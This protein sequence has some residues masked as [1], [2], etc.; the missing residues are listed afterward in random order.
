MS[1]ALFL[2]VGRGAL[3]LHCPFVYF[4]VQNVLDFTHIRVHT[5]KTEEQL[6]SPDATDQ[7]IVKLF[8]SPGFHF[9]A[10]RLLSETQH[11]SLRSYF[12]VYSFEI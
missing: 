3:R 2:L 8:S 1:V 4:T 5:H 6:N 11:C 9:D 12:P 10:W 7:L